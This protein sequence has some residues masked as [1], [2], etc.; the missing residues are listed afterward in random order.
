MPPAAG[1]LAQGDRIQVNPLM[2]PAVVQQPQP[3]PPGVMMTTVSETFAKDAIISWFRGEFAAANAIIDALCSHLTQLESGGAAEYQ[4]VFTAIHRRRMNWIPILHRQKYFSIADIPMEL[5]KVAAKKIEERNVAC[6]E[7]SDEKMKNQES[8][9]V[10][11]SDVIENAGGEAARE[12][13]ERD[14][15]PESEITDTGKSIEPPSV[16]RKSKLLQ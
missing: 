4:S 14:D 8:P 12:D 13:S 5:K 10:E 6:T 15:S 2:A 3:P 1:V 9:A 7:S 11:S 16:H